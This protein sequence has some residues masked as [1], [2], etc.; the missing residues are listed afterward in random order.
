MAHRKLKKLIEQTYRTFACRCRHQSC[1]CKQSSRSSLHD[2][3]LRSF[4][5]DNCGQSSQPMGPSPFARNRLPLQSD[6]AF[7]GSSSSWPGCTAS[8]GCPCGAIGCH[9]DGT[10]TNVDRAVNPW[11]R[12]PLLATAFHSSHIAFEGSSSSWPGCTASKGY[13]CAAIACHSDGT[14][15]L[16]AAQVT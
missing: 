1:Y 7:G 13:P 16:E 2:R 5:D 10:L 15:A 8:K 9:S 14:L 6:I 11:A 4:L 12:A 3:L